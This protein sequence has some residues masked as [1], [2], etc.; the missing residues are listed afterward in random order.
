MGKVTLKIKKTTLRSGLSCYHVGMNRFAFFCMLLF[1]FIAMA[2]AETA[3]TKPTKPK[4]LLDNT[5]PI[6]P[7]ENIAKGNIMAGF[8]VSLVQAEASDLDIIVGDLYDLDGYTF[9]VDAFGGYFFRD[10]LAAG[11]RGGYSRTKYTLHFS[12]LED[13]ADVDQERKYLSNGF[14]VQPFLRNCLKLFDSKS[15]YFFNETSLQVAYSY[16]ISQVDDTED[17]SKTRTQTLSFKLGLNP[18]VD[19]VLVEGFA[20][21]TS[22]GLLGLSS[23]MTDIEEN[24]EATSSIDYNIINFK[25][26]LLAL[27]FC[28]VYFF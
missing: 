4:P 15:I 9:S 23:S 16:G 19:V 1:S 10:A 3:L 2:Y 6:A 12:L 13:I 8:S 11:V 24:G 14:Y 21:E 22:V 7:E 27:D 17:I 25:V 26:N 28:L 20:F 18:G 5:I